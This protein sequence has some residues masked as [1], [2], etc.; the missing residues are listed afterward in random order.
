M[1]AIN[2]SNGGDES[3]A[4][5][6]TVSTSGTLVYVVGGPFPVRQISLTWIDRTGAGAEPLA[7]ASAASY[8]GP[9]LSPDGQKLAVSVRRV[10]PRGADLW[11][12]DVLRGA[13]TRLTFSGNNSQPVWSPDGKRL[14]YGSSTIEANGLY[15]IDADGG[16]KPERL[17]DV[18]SPSSWA[19][20]INAVAFLRRTESGSNGIWVLPM[21]GG[22]KPQL[23]LESRVSIPR[24]H[25]SPAVQGQGR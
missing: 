11:V 20:G 9:R 2:A 4:G 5:Q 12:Y 10:T 21:A 16:G 14:A 23:F 1:H 19:P 24:R 13:P 17:N 15:A 6:F 3:G 25:A 7:G 22:G 18:G 8:L